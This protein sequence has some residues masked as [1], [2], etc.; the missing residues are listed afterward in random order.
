[1]SG[2]TTF[3]QTSLLIMYAWLGRAGERV[4]DAS[5]EKVAPAAIEA[6]SKYLGF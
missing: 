6:I 4:L 5:L 3:P 2:F 1:M